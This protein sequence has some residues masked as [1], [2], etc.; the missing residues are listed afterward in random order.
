MKIAFIQR[1]AYEKI[2]VQQLSGC[3]KNIDVECDIFIKNLEPHF[4]DRIIT[5]QPDYILYSLFI[6]EES[7]MLESFSRLKQ[8]LPKS[9]TVVGGPFTLIFPEIIKNTQVDFVLRGDGEY[10]LPLFLQLCNNGESLKNVPGI[11]YR[12]DNGTVFINN[13]IKLTSDL[14]I[15][16]DPDRD[17]YYK[18]RDLADNDTKNFII[19][20]GCAYSCTFCYN[21][22]LKKYYDEIYWRMRDTESVFREIEYVK[23]TYGLKWVHFQDGTFNAHKKWLKP[24]LE[25]YKNRKLPPFLCN[26]RIENI[27]EEFISLMKESGCDRITFGIQSG[28]LSIRKNIAGRQMSNEQ[29]EAAFQLCHKYKIRVGADIIFGWPGETI[30]HAMDT[31]RLCRKLKASTYHSNVLIPYPGLSLTRD[32]VTNGYLDH[33]PTLNEISNLNKNASLIRQD[34][35]NWLINVD[36]LFY[37]LINYPLFEKFILFIVKLPPNK[38]FNLLKNIHLL[39][40]SLKYCKSTSKYRMVSNYVVNSWKKSHLPS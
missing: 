3:L 21:T 31:I 30:D 37:Y 22:E 9:K 6:G 11:S 7:F 34:N 36:K 4:Y 19:S 15:L 33:E 28:N 29:I 8:Y 38:L 17:L 27:D 20:R 10:S 12:E 40:R 2:G 35:I 13:N 39:L 14:K 26:C 25:E 24:F 32:S 1:D 23:N 18:Y 5:F 16:P